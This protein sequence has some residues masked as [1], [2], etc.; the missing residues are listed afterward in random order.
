MGI[1]T[2]YG[3]AENDETTPYTFFLKPSEVET[4][5]TTPY[6]FFLK[7]SKAETDETSRL[8]PSS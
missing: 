1:L 3:K 7:P 8:C 4:D 6:T 5:E 2:T